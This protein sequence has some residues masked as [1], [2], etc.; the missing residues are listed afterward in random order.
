MKKELMTLFMFIGICFI[1]FLIFRNL[2]TKE[3]M[4]SD[5]SGNRAS[6]SSSSSATGIAGNAATYAANIK[7]QTVKLT[8]I[9]LVSK[10]RSD[11]ENAI[12]NVDDLISNLMLKATLSLDQSNPSDGLKKIVELNMAKTALDKV[13]KFVD[14]SS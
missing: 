12:L 1:G 7:S 11:Y 2:N 9:L 13:M 8:D 5:A 10:Y 14:S 6:S 4:T 3:G